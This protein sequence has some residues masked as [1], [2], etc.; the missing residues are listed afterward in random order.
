MACVGLIDGRRV[1]AALLSDAR[2]K[3]VVKL[4]KSRQ[5]LMP[6]TGLPA[7]AKTLRL[8]GGITR[9]FSHFP[10]EAPEGY[11]SLES[12]EHMA[13]K[14]A[15]YEKLISLGIPAE[16][17]DG[18]EDWRADILVGSS[19]FS[20][21]LAIEVQITPQSSQRTYERTEQRQRS[22]IPT[23]WIFGKDGK[24]GHLA[25]DLLR[26]NP[27]FTVE[28]PEQA[29]EAAS[30]VCSGQAFFDDLSQYRETPAR[31]VAVLF[32]CECKERWL[33]PFGMVLLTNRISKETPPVFV[34]CFRTTKVGKALSTADR[35]EAAKA[36]FDLYM[37]A[38]K[39][40]SCQYNLS[41]GYPK[42]V[43]QRYGRFG[44]S[45]N[46]TQVLERHYCCPVCLKVPEPL[47]HGLPNG[48]D[49]LKCPTPIAGN[50]DARPVLN[51]DQCW[52][53]KKQQG[54]VE[55]VMSMAEW[56]STVVNPLKKAVKEAAEF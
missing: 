26:A 24:L 51:I 19:A 8:K 14:I 41:L 36:Y 20:E 5:V 1:I 12:P 3:E 46:R 7:Q 13:M 43:R 11:A 45:K 55:T 39:A 42:E 32:D 40:T 16:L 37:P 10:G 4:S 30:S 47:T 28:S 44:R 22:G 27:V 38:L 9:Y 52:R 25:E 50:V 49:L 2:W 33:Y 48:V 56:K 23:L 35:L 53:T 34:S 31:P 6:D 15:I 17:E 21:G 29:A 18:L 54:H